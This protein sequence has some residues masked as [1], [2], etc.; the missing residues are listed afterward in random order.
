MKEEGGRRKLS[1]SSFLLPPSSLLS[2]GFVRLMHILPLG[3]SRRVGRMLARVAYY[4]IPRIRKDGL[5]NLTLVYGDTITR[6]EKVRILKEAVTNLGLVAV[7][8]CRVPDL[9]GAFLDHHTIARGFE[10]VDARRGAIFI[11]AHLANWEW[12]APMIAVRGFKIAEVFRPLDDPRLNA[13]VKCLRQSH[14]IHTIPK[15]HAAREVVEKLK[16]GYIV[17][18]VV[19]QS[20]R[21]N[22][23]PVRFL[24][25]PCW[26]TVGPA[27]T[28]MRARVPVHAALM[29][30]LPDGRYE[31]TISPEIPMACS[32][33]THQD[34]TVNSQR[35]QD[36][37]ESAIRAHPG[38]WLW[39]HRRWKPR[40]R[41]EREWAERIQ[42]IRSD[43]TDPTDPSNPP[44]SQ[45]PNID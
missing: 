6:A 35:C 7:E 18:L 42:R 13:F 5:A 21:D 10:H 8:M 28:A 32:G 34:I 37:I 25:Q 26:G 27:I 2:I 44:E 29:A 16:E 3:A 41:L 45:P 38:Q 33:D 24:G 22:G 17:G 14:N 36:A 30:R 4:V 31:L 20:P 40:P 12:M 43:P 1:R 39:L 15:D 23:T 9:T 11:G 19:D